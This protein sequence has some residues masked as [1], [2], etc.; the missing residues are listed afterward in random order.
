[1]RRRRRDLALLKTLGFTRRQ[2]GRVVAWESSV[3][4]TIGTIVGIP[5]GIVLGRWLWD[6]FAH[7]L[8]V[9]SQPTIAAG[10]I[11]LVAVGALLL[12]NLVAAIPARPAAR[13]PTAVLIA[14]ASPRK[15]PS[16]ALTVIAELYGSLP[17]GPGLHSDRSATAG[18]VCAAVRAGK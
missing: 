14:A 18:R 10:T 1:M 8:D 17:A 15:R 11:V 6:L 5:L 7:E 16:P 9:I 13:T 12:A 4:V 2:L 3:A